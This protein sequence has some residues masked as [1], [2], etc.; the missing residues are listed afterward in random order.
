MRIPES[1]DRLFVGEARLAPEADDPIA[2]IH[3]GFG[4]PADP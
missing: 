3:L 2:A 1:A 4:A